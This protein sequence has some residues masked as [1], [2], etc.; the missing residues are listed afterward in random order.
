MLY[1]VEGFTARQLIK[2]GLDTTADQAFPL[3]QLCRAHRGGCGGALHIVTRRV[4]GDKHGRL[5]IQLW[6]PDHDAGLGGEL[7]VVGIHVNDVVEA[8]NRPVGP[9]GLAVDE[10]HRVF[11]AQAL[12]VGPVLLV[13]EQAGIAGVQLR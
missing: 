10:V 4:H 5:E 2:H 7:L 8:G 12:E 1:P 6:F 11:I 13:L 3:L 9:E